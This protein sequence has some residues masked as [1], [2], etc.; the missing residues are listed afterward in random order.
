M[1]HITCFSSSNSYLDHFHFL[2]F[3]NIAFMSIHVY[4]FL[5]S[6]VFIFLEYI[7]SSGIAGYYDNLVFYPMKTFELCS[8]K[9]PE[10]TL[11]NILLGCLFYSKNSEKYQKIILQGSNTYFLL[12]KHIRLI[13]C[14]SSMLNDIIEYSSR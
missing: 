3:M 12:L 8:V 5:W 9:K 13:S 6:C 14:I 1:T 2:A 7:P 10:P 11:L 4:I